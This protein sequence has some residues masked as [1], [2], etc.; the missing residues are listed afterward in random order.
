MALFGRPLWH[1]FK[2]SDEMLRVAK[3]KLIGGR[4]LTWFVPTDSDHVFAVLSFRLSLDVCLENPITLPRQKSRQFPLEGSRIHG[5]TY[6]QVEYLHGL[7]A[8]L[9]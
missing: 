6:G 1:A 2:D 3:T 5:P 4:K 9:G 8:C 7:G